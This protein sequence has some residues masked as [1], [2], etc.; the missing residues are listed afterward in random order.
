MSFN[1]SGKITLLRRLFQSLTLIVFILI[2]YTS[3]KQSFIL[4]TFYSLK[5]GPIHI[6]DPYV[7]ITYIIRNFANIDFYIWSFIGF[8]IPLFVGVLMGRVFCSWIC[9]YNFFY[10][11]IVSFIEKIKKQRKFLFFSTSDKTRI[12]YLLV[13]IIIGTIFPVLTY[14]LILPGLFSLLMHQIILYFFTIVIFGVLWILFIFTFDYF[15]KKRIWCKCLCPTG[16]ILSLIRFKRGLRIIKMENGLCKGCAL[17][18]FECP[19]GLTP[20]KGDH[21]AEC[22]NCG[23]C[24][25]ICKSLRKGNQPLK[26]KFL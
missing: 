6:V 8:M 11:C 9:P 10:E 24:V 23:K 7:Y 15:W 4:G 26:F 17:C 22:Y 1:I 16:V 14:L 12:V 2:Y 13:I 19:L 21:Y 3:H 5:I 20:H 18:S 25:D